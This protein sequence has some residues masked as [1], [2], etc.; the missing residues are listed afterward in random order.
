MK[1]CFYGCPIYFF[2]YSS[3]KEKLIMKNVETAFTCIKGGNQ[4]YFK[5]VSE[6][7][8]HKLVSK[9]TVLFFSFTD[10]SV[11]TVSVFVFYVISVAV[12]WVISNKHEILISSQKGKRGGN[13]QTRF[14]QFYMANSTFCLTCLCT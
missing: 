10:R 14:N 1:C 4:R 5:E 9:E 11:R 13:T 7:N 2:K 8:L 3:F 6:D 12:S